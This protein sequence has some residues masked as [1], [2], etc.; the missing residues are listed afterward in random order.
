MSWKDNKPYFRHFV[1]EI[2]CPFGEANSLAWV[3]ARIILLINKLDIQIIK[4]INH[5]FQQRGISLIYIISSSHMVV[6]TWPENNY[7]HIDLITCSKSRKLDNLGVIIKEV[8]PNFQY[9]I[10]EL[11]Y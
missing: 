7:I 4:D 11:S 3:K 5:L 2:E 1:V 8:F 6:H 9:K 10:S